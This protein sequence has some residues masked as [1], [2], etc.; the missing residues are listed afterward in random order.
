MVSDRFVSSD[1]SNQEEAAVSMVQRHGEVPL[2]LTKKRRRWTPA[3]LAS[4]IFANDMLVALY[5]GVADN[6]D[7]HGS[8]LLPEL[9]D[10][11]A[12]TLAV[13]AQNKMTTTWGGAE[14]G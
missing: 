10:Y 5:N 12:K 13:D 7:A 4:P 3:V 9:L 6:E 14:K 11:M 1:T 2:S 8:A